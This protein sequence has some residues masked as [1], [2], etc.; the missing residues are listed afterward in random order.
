MDRHDCKYGFKWHSSKW[1]RFRLCPFKIHVWRVMSTPSDVN[2][3]YEVVLH[4]GESMRIKGGFP[5]EDAACEY[6]IN[7]A[8]R[9]AKETLEELERIKEEG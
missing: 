9:L 4:Y 5:D 8:I 1:I 2:N 7:E 3:P 6:A